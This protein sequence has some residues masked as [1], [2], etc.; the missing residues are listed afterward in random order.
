[1]FGAA[2]TFDGKETTWDMIGPSMSLTPLGVGASAEGSLRIQPLFLI[3]MH[4]ARREI[5]LG[6]MPLRAIT[7]FSDLAASNTAASTDATLKKNISRIHAAGLRMSELIDS[8]LTLSRL[9]RRPLGA[10]DVDLSA[11]ASEIAT[12]LAAADPARQ[13]R[14]TLA[15]GLPDVGDP[16]LLRVAL[17]NLLQNAWKF[18]AT[19][20]D[21]AMEFGRTTVDGVAA[22][23]VRDNGAGFDARFVQKLFTPFERLHSAADFPGTGIGLATVERVVQRHGGSVWAEG[24]AGKGAAFFFTLLNRVPARERVPP[25]RGTSDV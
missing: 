25:T 1:M 2:S 3:W 11:L 13:V 8:L 24:Q 10:K 19:R 12:E 22:Y 9:T 17:Y 14:F 18:T 7:N 21:A 16:D 15:E 23:F 4:H 5:N 6:A 20:K